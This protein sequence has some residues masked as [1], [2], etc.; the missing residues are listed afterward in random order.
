MGWLSLCVNLIRLRDAQLA[1]KTLFLGL[2]VRMFLKEISI[3]FYRLSKEDSLT[4]HQSN[5][6]GI[7]IERTGKQRANSLPPF[8]LSW[9]LYLLPPSDIGVPGSQAFGLGLIITLAFLIF[10]LAEDRLWGFS[11]SVTT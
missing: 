2:F 9:D 11:A 7:Q 5:L 6:L 8:F 10:R 3:R 1:G 4:R